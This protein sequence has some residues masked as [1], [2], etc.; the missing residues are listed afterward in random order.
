MDQ[1]SIADR[2]FEKLYTKA[3]T[4][5]FAWEITK[6]KIQEFEDRYETI[7]DQ[8]RLEY[9]AHIDNKYGR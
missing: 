7:M 1:I 2:E 9:T 4:T 5:L 8:R 6:A 3:S